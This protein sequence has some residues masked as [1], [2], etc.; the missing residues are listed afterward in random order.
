MKTSMIELTCEQFKK[1]EQNG[2]KVDVVQMENGGENLKL[3][4]QAQSN[5]WKLGIMFEKTARD[6]SQQNRLAEIGITVVAN[7]A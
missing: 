4:K 1:W 7:K 5:N 6:I 3:E 2:H